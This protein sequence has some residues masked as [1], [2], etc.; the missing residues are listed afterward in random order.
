MAKRQAWR[1]NTAIKI[2]NTDLGTQ[3]NQ[4]R[5]SERDNRSSKRGARKAPDAAGSSEA[6]MKPAA[7]ANHPARDLRE[8]GRG[9]VAACACD[10]PLDANRR[11][12]TTC[13]MGRDGTKRAKRAVL[14]K[15]LI[16]DVTAKSECARTGSKAI[17]MNGRREGGRE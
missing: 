2:T 3:T 8:E 13:A 17:G 14:P 15:T 11:V 9:I 4:A 16:I 1:H 12:R 6:A 5:T 7:P 10:R